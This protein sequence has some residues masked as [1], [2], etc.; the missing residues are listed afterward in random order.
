[1]N[2]IYMSII[3]IHFSAC[4]IALG[5][6]RSKRAINTAVLY[7]Y[8]TS[9]GDQ[10]LPDRDDFAWPVEIPLPFRFFEQSYT[11]IYVSKDIVLE[12]LRHL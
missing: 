2:M 8:G 10:A 4:S 1:M 9:A 11:T 7:P 6:L 12:S 5:K 3:W